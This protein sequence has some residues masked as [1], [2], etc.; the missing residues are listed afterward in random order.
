MLLCGCL[1]GSRRLEERSGVERARVGGVAAVGRGGGVGRVRRT[2]LLGQVTRGVDDGC[3]HLRRDFLLWVA[4]ERRG[5]KEGEGGSAFVLVGKEWRGAGERPSFYLV[6]L[7]SSL[8]KCFLSVAQRQ[9]PMLENL[10][11]SRKKH[12]AAH[13]RFCFASRS[14]LSLSPLSGYSFSSRAV[15]TLRVYEREWIGGV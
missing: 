5:K 13:S 10:P 12:L 6:P 9:L 15:S 11:S 1:R 14:D 7:T 2:V 4:E 8:R 3:G